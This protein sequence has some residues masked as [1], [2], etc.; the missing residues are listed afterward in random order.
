MGKV[1]PREGTGIRDLDGERRRKE[2]LGARRGRR[3]CFG[4]CSWTFVA[5]ST[6]QKGTSGMRDV[7]RGGGR[8]SS[9]L[10]WEVLNKSHTNRS[11]VGEPSSP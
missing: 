5:V 3:K 10:G 9:W 1:C 8:S 4:V 6:R 2:A 11:K 7:T